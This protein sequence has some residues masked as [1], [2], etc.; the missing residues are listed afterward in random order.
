VRIVAVLNW[1]DEE[2]RLLA[3]CVASLRGVADHLVA[4]DGAYSLF[5]D[6]RA[7]SGGG[8]AE[9]I[10]ETARSVGLDAT[11]HVPSNVWRGNEVEKRNASLRIAL[12][13]AEPFED[14]ILIVDADM[15]VTRV[16]PFLRK[17]LA[18]TDRDVATYRSWWNDAP[19]SEAETRFSYSF[20]ISPNAGE[21][22]VRCLYRALP[23]LSYEL[24]H[25]FVRGER[26]DG[27]VTYLNGR[28]DFHVLAEAADVT[29]SLQ[30]EHRHA[31]RSPARRK[32]AEDY[33]ELRDATGAERWVRTMIE[34]VDGELVEK[35]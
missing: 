27:S 14:W 1:Y 2:P 4:V 20:G 3:P 29:S 15:V 23:N 6:G 24:T 5:P 31:Q 21:V 35:L 10:L 30:F 32:A 25:Y 18:E 34:G 11:V 13:H 19:A 26:R 9:L 7:S 12:A 22:I 28:R 17:D 16:S 8:Q 33:Y